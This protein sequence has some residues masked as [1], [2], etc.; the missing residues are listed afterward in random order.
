MHLLRRF[1]PPFLIFLCA[2][3]VQAPAW[4]QPAIL[5]ILEGSATLVR[6]SS[7]FGLVEG[8][9]L[10]PTDIVDTGATSFAQIELKDGVRLGLGAS[11]RVMLAPA[12][13]GLG[14]ARVYLLQGWLKV[15]QPGANPAAGQVITPRITA[16]AFVGASVMLT[17]PAQFAVFVEG[18]ALHSAEREGAE[19]PLALKSGDFASSPAGE[20]LAQARRPSAEFL[21]KMPR[22]FRDPLPARAQLYKDKDIQPR[23]QGEVGYDAVAGWL[24]AEPAIRLPLLDRWR[25][26]LKDQAFRAG[27]IA[28]FSRHP[29]WR[30]VVFPPPPP[31]PAAPKPLLVLPA[32]APS[33]ARPP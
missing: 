14:D 25:G 2:A 31:K 3:A 6:Q 5:T 11:T 19:T 22:Q 33:A 10:Q 8:A 4:A 16:S 17:D 9:R 20:K 30:P 15:T 1:A 32:S 26:R 18:G 7:K 21:D 29:E 13:R 27:V 23:P 24:Q 28:N 12:G